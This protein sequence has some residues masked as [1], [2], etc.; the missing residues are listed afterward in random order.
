MTD[1]YERQALF[2]LLAKWAVL[3]GTFELSS[4]QTSD[5]YCDVKKVSL[6]PEGAYLV[7]R[8]LYKLARQADP[9]AIAT[10]GLTLGADPLVTAIAIASHMAQ[11]PMDALI[12]RKLTKDHGTSNAVEMPVT[13]A[14]HTSKQVVAVDDVI[15][16]ASST[17]KAIERLREAGFVVDHAV[18]VVDREAGGRQALQDHGVT[19][20]ALFTLSDFKE[21]N[22]H[23]D[24]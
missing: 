16:T 14:R 19:L 12:V 15:T 23:E 20:H 11:D 13:T 2:A 7:G 4:G 1:T 9:N 17:L 24:Q 22:I 10:G 3:H 6:L 8:A 21:T 18:C 5:I